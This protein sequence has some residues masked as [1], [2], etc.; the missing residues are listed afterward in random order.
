MYLTRWI[1]IILLYI[2]G[3]ASVPTN[4]TASPLSGQAGIRVSWTAPTLAKGLTNTGYAIQY[5]IQDDLDHAYMNVTV[6][7][8]TTQRDI[9]GLK[10]GTEYHIRVATI[11]E[12]GTGPYCCER[13]A[14]FAATSWSFVYTC[15]LTICVSVG[16][17][18]ILYRIAVW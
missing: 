17:A 12:L 15:I 7:A 1:Y 18:S 14:I 6:G 4:V 5:K 3:D 2:A 16:N 9:T 13:I 11:T 10:S 8:G